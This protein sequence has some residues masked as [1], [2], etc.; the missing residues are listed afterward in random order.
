MA[1]IDPTARYANVIARLNNYFADLDIPGVNK[2]VLAGETGFVPQSNQPWVRYSITNVDQKNDGRFNS[3]QTAQRVEI[4]I[5]ADV[6]F[7][8]GTETQ[9][10]NA[11]AIVDA[12]D[13][14]AHNLRRLNLSFID[15]SSDPANPSTVSD[16]RIRT[17]LPPSIERLP[18]DGGFE[19]RQVTLTV[20]WHLRHTL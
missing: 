8:D 7:P 3:A 20:M 4:L 1:A 6:F 5:T 15:Y 16:A 10:F 14:V 2:A 13:A 17:L 18:P 11:Y 12:A 19:R 9:P